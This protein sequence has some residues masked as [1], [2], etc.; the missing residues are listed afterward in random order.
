MEVRLIVGVTAI[1]NPDNDNGSDSMYPYT[2]AHVVCV[3]DHSIN[4]NEITKKQKKKTKK[5]CEKAENFCE[6]RKRKNITQ[7]KNTISKSQAKKKLQKHFNSIFSLVFS[8]ILRQYSRP[9]SYI[10]F[11]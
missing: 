4:E 11:V 8:F 7:S 2:V 5:V 3:C 6:R 10:I 1:N 9:S